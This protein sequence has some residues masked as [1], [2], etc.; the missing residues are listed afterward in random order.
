M[1]EKTNKKTET[2]AEPL[3][4]A[5]DDDETEPETATEDDLEAPEPEPEPE[6]EPP[7]EVDREAELEAEAADLR[8]KLLR[9]LAET[10]NV[11]R[12][13]GRDR[14]DA[15]KYAVTNFARELL[16]VADN[17]RRAVDSVPADLRAGNEAVENLMVGVEMTEKAMLDAFDRCGIKPI[18]A[19]GQR[20]DHNLHEALF[21]LEDKEQPAGTVVQVIE[22]GFVLH[23]RLLRPAKVGVSKGGPKAEAEAE[24][25]EEST[26]EI[27]PAEAAPRASTDVY[28]KPAETGA[29]LDE[30]L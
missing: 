25:P 23:D 5:V 19:L 21:E 6:P 20:F 9:A 11:R 15:F 8:D 2:P 12:R 13:A 17:L 10:E 14:E 16:A 29:Q 3:E 18:E 1:F 26:P 28:E 22:A 27:A 24:A 4:A 30:K 7:E